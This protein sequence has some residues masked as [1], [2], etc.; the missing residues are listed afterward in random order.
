[1]LHG[2]KSDPSFHARV[3]EVRSG[4]LPRTGGNGGDSL[5]VPID[6]ASPD[7][8]SSRCSIPCFETLASVIS[9]GIQS[10]LSSGAVS[11]HAQPS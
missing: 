4:E 5:A 1:M 9:S 2:W 10:G 6:G 8:I 3:R 11:S 7:Q